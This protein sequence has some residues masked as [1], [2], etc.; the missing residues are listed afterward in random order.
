MVSSALMADMQND[1]GRVVA[2]CL[3]LLAALII[4]CLGL[5]YFRRRWLT[6]D[7]TPTVPWTLDDLCK[8]RDQG[9][10]SEAEYESMREVIIAK[11][12]E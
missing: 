6:V 7:D 3:F 4:M 12:G 5:W 1:P 10:L 8:L 2:V 9:K 11:Y